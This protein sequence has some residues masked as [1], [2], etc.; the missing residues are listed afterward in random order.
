VPLSREERA[1]LTDTVGLLGENDGANSM[2]EWPDDDTIDY[3]VEPEPIH[4]LDAE[5]LERASWHVR[6]IA[7]RRRELEQLGDVYRNELRRI[8]DRYDSVTRRINAGIAWHEVPVKQLHAALLAVDPRRKTIALPYGTMRAT[9]PVKARIFITDP[10]AAQE[11]ALTNHPDLCPPKQVLVTDLRRDLVARADGTVIDPATG[12]CV[13]CC[14]AVVPDATFGV[15][16][17][18]GDS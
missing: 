13:D 14:T 9:V 2:N 10:V 7:E 1:D 8:T 17:D 5:A 16:T 18:L 4:G 12:E 11:W 3:A 15:D 6:K